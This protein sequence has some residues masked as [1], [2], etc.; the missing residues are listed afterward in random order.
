MI[1]ALSTAVASSMTGS[2][3]V[4]ACRAGY[5]ANFTPIQ[6][7]FGRERSS[8]TNNDPHVA[9]GTSARTDEAHA[10]V[11][12]R[13]EYPGFST[14]GAAA[15]ERVAATASPAATAVRTA[16]AATAATQM[17]ARPSIRVVR[18]GR[19][20][21]SAART[22]SATP[23]GLARPFTR[24]GPTERNSW[25]PRGADEGAH[26]LGDERLPGV[27]DRAQP[28]RF[29]DRCPEPVVVLAGGFARADADPQVR[30]RFDVECFNL[31][32][33][34]RRTSDGI[35]SAVA[36]HDHE[37]VA[38]VLD[39]I[40]VRRVCCRAQRVEEFPAKLVGRVVAQMFLAFRRR[41]EIA[42]EDADGRGAPLG[43]DLPTLHRVS[44]SP[45]MFRVANN[46][47]EDGQGQ[48]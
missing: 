39:D 46:T 11:T 25:P 23:R 33:H 47:A 7:P 14:L 40:A 24:T 6:R 30:S 19:G 28:R 10:A 35:H 45:T 31:V 27:G 34:A 41:D 2:F 43:V 44:V 42:E 37:S 38:G 21:N 48:R 12:M 32:M 5:R 18:R 15:L 22:T 13:G 26:D 20:A 29:D 8:G 17:R 1:S 36:E 4:A 9:F 3:A 16:S